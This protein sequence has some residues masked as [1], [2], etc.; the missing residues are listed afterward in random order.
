M[1]YRNL[2]DISMKSSKYILHHIYEALKKKKKKEEFSVAISNKTV[3]ISNYDSTKSYITVVC[4]LKLYN[5]DILFNIIESLVLLIF[6]LMKNN[7]NFIVQILT[8]SYKFLQV[9]KFYFLLNL[10]ILFRKIMIYIY[11]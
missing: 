6:R 3:N 7:L 4:Y 5:F 9:Y 1:K 10:N 2:L 11:I 8:N